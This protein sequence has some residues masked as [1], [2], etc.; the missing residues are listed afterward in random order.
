ML[1]LYF[2]STLVYR[3]YWQL[4]FFNSS[5]VSEPGDF[6][7]VLFKLTDPGFLFYPFLWLIQFSKEFY[8]YVYACIILINTSLSAKTAMKQFS[9]DNMSMS[10]IMMHS[11]TLTYAD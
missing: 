7:F 9:N 2:Y 8:L 6:Y 1:V 5:N 3:S 10:A 11:P 4:F